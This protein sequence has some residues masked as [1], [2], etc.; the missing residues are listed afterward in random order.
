RARPE[1]SQLRVAV[2]PRT[3]WISDSRDDAMTKRK[4]RSAVALLFAVI[5]L[6]LSSFAM[7]ARADDVADEA[8]HLFTL[9]AEHYQKK[10]YKEA[11]Q[12]FL[13]SNRLVRNRNVMFNIAR[14]YEHLQQF[15]DAYRYYQR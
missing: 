7:D 6:L 11:L 13:A 4:R 10:D 12:Y 14:T 5:A 9:G 2:S 8:D 1:N 3:I 15:P